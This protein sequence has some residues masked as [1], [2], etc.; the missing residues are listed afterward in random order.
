MSAFI[1]SGGSLL[2]IGCP[3]NLSRETEQR[4]S[5]RTTK[6]GKRKGFVRKGGRRTW[7]V[8]VSVAH[9]GEVSTIE[10]A[11]RNMG[12]VGWYDAAATIGNLLSPQASGWEPVPSNTVDAGLVQLLDGTIAR[13]VVPTTGP[14]GVVSPGDAHGGYEMVPVRPGQPV[15]VGGWGVGG[16]RFTGFWRDAAQQPL[17]SLAATAHSFNGWG[18]RENTFTPPVGAAFINMSLSQGTQYALPSI[19]WG[20]VGRPEL[21]T[22]CPKAVVHSPAHSPVALWKGTNLTD[23]S[24]TV[25]EVG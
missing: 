5:F 7:S 13:T 19:A 11:A 24:Y 22:G 9:P 14:T 23:S 8:D 15:T 18:W 25:T 21:G 1:V 17:G 3:S 20:A 4:A 2:E 16:I 12:L 6:G 10:A